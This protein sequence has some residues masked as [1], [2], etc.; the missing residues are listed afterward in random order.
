VR[1]TRATVLVALRQ[2]TSSLTAC[3]RPL[4]CVLPV[5]PPSCLNLKKQFTPSP[6]VR[7]IVAIDNDG[8]ELVLIDAEDRSRFQG[9]VSALIRKFVLSP[10]R[11]ASKG[12]MSS[13]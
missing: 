7:W 12:D 10:E 8:G 4:R 11:A 5:S 9:D 13:S 2:P 1:R 3:A 6:G